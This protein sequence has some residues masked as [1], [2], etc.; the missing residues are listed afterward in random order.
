[1][2]RSVQ[3]KDEG[4]CK[5]LVGARELVIDGRGEADTRGLGVEKIAK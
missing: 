5:G 1:V 2:F 3:D 4:E